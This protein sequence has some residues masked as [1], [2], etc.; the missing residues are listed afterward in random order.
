MHLKTLLLALTSTALVLADDKATTA[1]FFGAEVSIWQPTYSGIA[2]SVA[3][4]NARE[5]TYHISCTKDAPKSLCQIEKPWT[6]IQAQESWSLTGVYTAWSSEK[7]AVT[8]TQDYSC[9]FKHWSE[10]ASCALTMQATGTMNG[11]SWSSSTSTKVSVASNKVT[12]YGLLVTGGVE[13]F[14]MPQ[15]TQTPGA[16]VVGVPVARAVATGMPLAGAAAVAVA[17]MF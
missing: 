3:G 11:G 14:T 12:T 15:A 6:M 8:A 4:I 17:A 5:T 1:P 16:A 13:S 9:T 2:G 10:S 7:D